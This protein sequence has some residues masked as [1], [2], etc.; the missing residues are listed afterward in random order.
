MDRR[1]EPVRMLERS[2]ARQGEASAIALAFD[3]ADLPWLADSY[4]A[5]C[6]QLGKV[7][8]SSIEELQAMDKAEKVGE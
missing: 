8:I 6:R 1:F 4:F 3:N 7:I 5:E 2:Q